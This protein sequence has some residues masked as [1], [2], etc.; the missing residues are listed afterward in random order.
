MSL[1]LL[2]L[3]LCCFYPCMSSAIPDEDIFEPKGNKI[4]QMLF[5]V[6]SIYVVIEIRSF[7][8]SWYQL[9]A[10][11]QLRTRC[12][13]SSI[14]HSRCFV[15]DLSTIDNSVHCSGNVIRSKDIGLYWIMHLFITKDQSVPSVT[16]LDQSPSFLNYSF[17]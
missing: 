4:I 10:Y 3:Y 15:N 17:S 14:P 9:S 5:S 13:P 12:S 1:L 7:E 11:Q 2:K 8:H 16:I 6:I